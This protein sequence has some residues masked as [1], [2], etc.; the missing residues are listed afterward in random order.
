[1]NDLPLR[2]TPGF[3]FVV[4]DHRHP[5]RRQAPVRT[6]KARHHTRMGEVLDTALAIALPSGMQQR[7]VA[8]FARGQKARFD[9]A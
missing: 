4:V 3:H 2:Q 6:D 5:A 9:G 8:R 7:Q 1:M